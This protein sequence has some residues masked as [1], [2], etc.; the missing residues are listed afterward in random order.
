M[1][2]QN[3]SYKLDHDLIFKLAAIHCTYQEIADIVGTTVHNLEKRFKHV[4]EK[5]RSEG[6]KSLR[7]A[8]FDKA[9]NGDVRMQMWLGKQYLGQADQPTDEENTEPLPWESAD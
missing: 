6:K 2:A 3:K 7:K 1:D 9:L 8:Q 4:I 5:A